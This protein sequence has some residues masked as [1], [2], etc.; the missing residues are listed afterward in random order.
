MRRRG[1]T[2]ALLA[3]T[4][5]LT[6]TLALASS[7]ALASAQA[8]EGWIGVP[9]NAPLSP[10][11]ESAGAPAVAVNPSGAEV[12]AWVVGKSVLASV[13][14]PGGGAYGAP[15]TLNSPTASG[16][17]QAP[18]VA[19]DA[20]GDT[21]VA[22]DEY[23]GSTYSVQ[24]ASGSPGQP[25]APGAAAQG[26][27]ST[28]VL[29][30]GLHAMFLADGTA[31]VVWAPFEGAI[32]YIL[33]PP[34]GSFGTTASLANTGVDQLAAAPAGN[35]A[36][37]AW[38]EFT[39]SSSSEGSTR[40]YVAKAAN[41]SSG[42][43]L[44]GLQTLD[45]V[46]STNANNCMEF[47]SCS[48]SAI[49]G[50]GVAADAAGHG[51]A[52]YN[53]STSFA[54]T[55]ITCSARALYRSAQGAFA[56]PASSF[57]QG[58]TFGCPTVAGAL[59]SDGTALLAWSE[60]AGPLGYVERAPAG[61]FP[62]TA[63]KLTP[64]NMA[65]SYSEPRIVP[66]GQN[67]Q[68][69]YLR[70]F[71]EAQAQSFTDAGPQG[72]PVALSAGDRPVQGPALSGDGNGDAVAV[73]TRED[74][75]A[76]Q[77][78]ES[79]AYDTGP[80][81]SNLAVPAS[82]LAGESLPFGV[83]AIDP[84]S[85]VTVEWTFG[86]GAKATGAGV[87]HAYATPGPQTASAVATDAGGLTSAP[88]SGST[89]VAP[90]VVHPGPGPGPGHGTSPSASLKVPKQRLRDVLRKGLAVSVSCSGPCRPELTLQVP[91]GTAKALGLAGGAHMAVKI[92]PPSRHVRKTVTLGRLV[93]T[94]RSGGTKTVRVKLTKIA[95]L[96]LRHTHKLT[97]SVVESVGRGLLTQQITLR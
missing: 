14:A 25:V 4:A 94:F 7:L 3:A 11:G 79:A 42:G 83:T 53:V 26:Q 88:V 5:A 37:L 93:L 78:V 64:P 60:G 76:N 49:V 47:F 34:G 80:R 63:Q 81:L 19:I 10:A 44:S 82:G 20:A 66:Q 50:L 39:F 16:F 21:L 32:E 71:K 23:N 36:L 1:F 45:T 15:V 72:T 91:L 35:S 70:N 9:S 92:P 90:V 41:L 69:M 48:D 38:D 96:H 73:W 57:A 13:R 74:T 24:L 46:S 6:L 54:I 2:L 31:L 97:L 29:T 89:Q 59:L 30:V 61:P 33:R 87:T 56:T 95:K 27:S 75:A 12:L 77:R 68:L 67:A 43:A 84:L 62:A 65:D 8:S 28:A 40:T 22:W 52:F 58:G 85:P 17:V 55:F 18:S 51:L 86:D